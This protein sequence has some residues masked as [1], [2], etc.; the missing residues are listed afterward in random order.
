MK[1]INTSAALLLSTLAALGG[2]GSLG[3]GIEVREPTIPTEAELQW[4]NLLEPFRR[5]AWHSNF[6][7]GLTAEQRRYVNE[8]V[9]R[10][11]A[12]ES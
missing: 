10:H 8:E 6:K 9:A 11:A 7:H 5:K 4:M 3:S 12:E 1:K 2:L